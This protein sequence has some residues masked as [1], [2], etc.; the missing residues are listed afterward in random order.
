MVFP[1]LQYGNSGG[2]LVN[3]VSVPYSGSPEFSG[4][5]FTLGQAA[6]PPGVLGTQNTGLVPS[7]PMVWG[8]RRGM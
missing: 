6:Q 4:A 1:P 7:H 3:L 5:L 8:P 2:P